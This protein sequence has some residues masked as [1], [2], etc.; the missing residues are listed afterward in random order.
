MGE[1]VTPENLTTAAKKLAYRVLGLAPGWYDITLLKRGNDDLTI[2]VA[3][4]GRAETL[5]GRSEE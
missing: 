3:E 1:L 2:V 5:K 4:R